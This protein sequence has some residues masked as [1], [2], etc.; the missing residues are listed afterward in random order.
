M[1]GPIDEIRI[2]RIKMFKLIEIRFEIFLSRDRG[3]VP[4]RIRGKAAVEEV[5]TDHRRTGQ[6]RLKQCLQF[7]ARE[8]MRGNANVFAGC[9]GDLHD[10]AIVVL[11][12]CTGFVERV[13][14]DRRLAADGAHGHE[15]GIG[16]NTAQFRGHV[17]MRG[18]RQMVEHTVEADGDI[19][20]GRT[21]SWPL[22]EILNGEIHPDRL[23]SDM[24]GSGSGQGDHAWRDIEAKGIDAREAEASGPQRHAPQPGAGSAT[25]VQDRNLFAP[26][27]GKTRQRGIQPAPYFPVCEIMRG[28]EIEE[29]RLVAIG[30]GN[31]VAPGGVVDAA[32][33]LGHE[34]RHCGGKPGF[35]V[36]VH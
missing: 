21:E 24:G 22:R 10:I 36:S 29:F 27:G 32:C 9:Q 5:N 28:G 35:G 6:M 11:V 3:R 12:K 7:V 31:I 30:I 2:R 17:A 14:I 16:R 1:R 20:F 26:I 23:V 8:Q 33:V 25:G 18:D 13:D 4:S 15:Q 19:E 34:R